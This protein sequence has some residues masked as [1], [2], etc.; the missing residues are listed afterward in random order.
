MTVFDNCS[1]TVSLYALALFYM[2]VK[3]DLSQ[4]RPLS[5]FACVKAIVFFSF[6]QGV[7]LAI[8]GSV[9]AI[10]ASPDYAQW[11][12]ALGIQDTMICVEMFLISIAMHWAFGYEEYLE[13]STEGGRSAL[14]SAI[15]SQP[16]YELRRM[17]GASGQVLNF[18][19]DLE[20]AN[21][22]L[23]PQPIRKRGNEDS[24][25]D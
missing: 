25:S 22:T 17:A 10:P 24:D 16:V 12:V 18:R 4:Y 5:K 14:S 23:A 20:D 15:R 7:L 19:D 21:Q 1:V 6:W 13:H 8:L 11:Q 9:G 2:A 3:D